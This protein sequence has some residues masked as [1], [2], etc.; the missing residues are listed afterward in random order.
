[1][2]EWK[3]WRRALPIAG[4]LGLAACGAAGQ[5]ASTGISP[6]GVAT[7]SALTTSTESVAATSTSTPSAAPA[8]TSASTTS[9]T[10]TPRPA[11]PR[12]TNAVTPP[13]PPP[14]AP[15]ASTAPPA[16]QPCGV[17]ITATDYMFS[18]ASPTVPHGCALSMYDGGGYHT[19]TGGSF[20]S[21]QMAP[22]QTYTFV[23]Q[24]PG[25]YAY[26]CQ[27]HYQAPYFMMGTIHV[28]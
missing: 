18:P 24:S 26:R 23:F 7:A 12:P 6:A 17:T 13:P 3:S 11:T 4:A 15:P 2:A 19:F 8:A 27:N 16:A 21:G 25:N 1:M 14:T 22:G 9:S 5:P 20:D 28:T 10:S